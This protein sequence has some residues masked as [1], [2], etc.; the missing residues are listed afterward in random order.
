MSIFP[1]LISELCKTTAYRFISGLLKKKKRSTSNTLMARAKFNG[2]PFHAVEK[3][4]KKSCLVCNSSFTPKS[5][6]NK[7][8]SEQCKGRWKYITGQVSTDS[9]YKEIS[10]NWKRYL[11]RLMYHGGRR[12]DKLNVDI[13]LSTLKRQDYKCALSGVPLTCI[14]SKGR[15][16]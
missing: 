16:H 13:L 8:C 12:R 11:S 6:V 10:G 14:L 7:F 4:R 15:K 3:I 1:T 9:Q 5:G 2:V